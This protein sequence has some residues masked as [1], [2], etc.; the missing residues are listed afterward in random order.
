MQFHL[1]YLSFLTPLPHFSKPKK[2]ITKNNLL[3]VFV[4][5]IIS[6]F[7]LE[8]MNVIEENSLEGYLYLLALVLIVL[9]AITKFRDYIE[10]DCVQ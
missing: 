7:D 8:A 5:F 3:I 10:N 6:D 1:F 4:F 2:E 9:K